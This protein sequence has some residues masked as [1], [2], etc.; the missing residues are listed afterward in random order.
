M[1]V[2]PYMSRA[3]FAFLGLWE[4]SGSWLKACGITDERERPRDELISA[5]RRFVLPALPG[6]NR[7]GRYG[8]GWVTI[9]DARVGSFV[10][11]DRERCHGRR[12]A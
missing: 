1:K 9:H 10:V 6:P 7:E 3:R 5:A 11:L 12:G 2:T 4:E 8:V